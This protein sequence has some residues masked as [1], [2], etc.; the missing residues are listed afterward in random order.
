MNISNEQ[1]GLSEYEM[2]LDQLADKIIKAKSSLERIG[3]LREYFKNKRTSRSVIIKYEQLPDYIKQK[4]FKAHKHGEL[5]EDDEIVYREEDVL[6][7]LTY[8]LE[9]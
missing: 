4:L 6:E 9:S 3:V 7:I 5:V 2:E 1:S 8:L